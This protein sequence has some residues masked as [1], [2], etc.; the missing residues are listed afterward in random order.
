VSDINGNIFPLESLLLLLL[1][2]LRRNGLLEG[3][4]HFDSPTDVLLSNSSD[5][6]T[7]TDTDNGTTTSFLAI[8]MRVVH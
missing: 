8:S 7:D 5:T 3:V 1:L 2:L 4:A 6:D